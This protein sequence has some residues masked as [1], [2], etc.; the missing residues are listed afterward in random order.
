MK[1]CT[2]EPTDGQ[3]EVKKYWRCVLTCFDGLDPEVVGEEHAEDGNALVVIRASYGPVMRFLYSIDEFHTF[4]GMC[5]N[6]TL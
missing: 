2:Y 4:Q 1:K 5:F 6:L 3:G